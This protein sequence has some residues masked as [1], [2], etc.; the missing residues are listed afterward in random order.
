MT[1]YGNFP[2]KNNKHITLKLDLDNLSDPLYTF[3]FSVLVSYSGVIHLRLIAI[4]SFGFD[5]KTGLLRW[6]ATSVD[7]IC[8]LADKVE[9]ALIYTNN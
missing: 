3:S 9:C 8:A 5:I 6:S 7:V 2:I 4:R 1:F